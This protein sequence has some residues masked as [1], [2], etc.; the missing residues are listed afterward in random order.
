VVLPLL[1][2]GAG[3]LALL[4]NFGVISGNQL[5]R[6]F[7]LWPAALVLLGVVLICR[8]W[9]PRLAVPL[10]AILVVLLVLGAFAYSTL[11]PGA[12][13]V[14]ARSDYSAPL[15]RVEHGRLQVE[16]AGSSVSVRGENIPDLY[17]GRVQYVSGHPPEVRVENGTV[18]L[19]SGSGFNLFGLRGADDARISLNKSITWDVEVGGGASRNTLELGS[20]QLTSLQLSGGAQQVEI[21]LPRPTGTVPI[22]ISGGASTITVHRPSGVAAQV[23]MSGGASNLTVDGDHRSV[24]SGDISWQSS[25]Y[26]TASDRYDFDISGG[27]SN[28][29]I[30]QR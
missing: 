5:V 12:S 17:R 4:L 18:A 7:D 21:T 10:A 26:G 1:L 19:R 23:R 2:I 9:L 22:R 24:L 6:A 15:G 16:L 28:V 8:A 3:V 13:V 14:S 30:D 20:V 11:L 27:A 25:G 29:T